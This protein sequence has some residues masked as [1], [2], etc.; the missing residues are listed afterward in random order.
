MECPDW[1]AAERHEKPH[2][3]ARVEHGGRVGRARRVRGEN[4]EGAWGEHGG[5][6]GRARR[7][8]GAGTE[9]AWGGHRRHIREHGGHVGAHGGYMGRHEG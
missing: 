7:V 6:V 3:H 5:R 4:M 1:S 8:R 2:R 9:G